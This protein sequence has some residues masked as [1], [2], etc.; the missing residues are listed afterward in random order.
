M[1]ELHRAVTASASDDSTAGKGR[2]AQTVDQDPALSSHRG[3]VCPSCR[4]DNPLDADTCTGCSV[5]F[6]ALLQG[7]PATPSRLHSVV[8]GLRELVVVFALFLLWKFASG[9]SAMDAGGAFARGRWIWRLERTLHLPSEVAVQRGILDHPLDVQIVNVFYLAAHFGGIIVFLLWLY[10]CHRPLYARWRNVIA[11][12]T[13]LSLLIQ[14]VSVA[15][16]RL[17]PDLGFVDTAA[18]YHQSAYQHLG[19][20]LVAQLSTMPSIH[21]GWAAA[22]A[23]AVILVSHSRWRWLVL[24]HPILTMYAV[25]ATANHFWLD[26]VAA[27]ALVALIVLVQRLV[28]RRHPTMRSAAPELRVASQGRK[29]DAGMGRAIR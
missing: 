1:Q 19:H 25:V 12:F 16:P 21:V 4:H 8:A 3:W 27:I 11:V 23:L 24:L 22:I 7:E 2:P 5:S 6:G 28:H 26:G 17:L 15:P 20:G 18:R 13:G 10:I 14:L 29:S 9:V